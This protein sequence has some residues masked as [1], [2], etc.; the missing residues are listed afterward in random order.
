MWNDRTAKLTGYDKTEAL[1]Q[2]L[3][4]KF[5]DEDSK[6]SVREDARSID[7][8]DISLMIKSKVAR[9]SQY[10]KFTKI[11]RGHCAH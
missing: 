3:V 9:A 7:T 4:E 1:G 6:A 8:V 2:N 11:H 10:A 5:I